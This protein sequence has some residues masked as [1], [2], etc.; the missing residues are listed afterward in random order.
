MVFATDSD[1]DVGSSYVSTAA[2][3]QT[4]ILGALHTSPPPEMRRT[5]GSLTEVTASVA[6]S[7][8]PMEALSHVTTEVFYFLFLHTHY[9]YAATT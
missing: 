5:L 7:G 9:S 4:L 1:S 2:L 6:I 8:D 3:A